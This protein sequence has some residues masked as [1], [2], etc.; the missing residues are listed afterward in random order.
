MVKRLLALGAFVV[1]SA[2]L[3]AQT[4]VITRPD[5]PPSATACAQGCTIQ[6]VPPSPPIPPPVDPPPPPPPP[7]PVDPPP[8][9]PPTDAR[10]IFRPD[11][12][13]AAFPRAG[14]DRAISEKFGTRWTRSYLPTGGPF[15]GPAHR[16]TELA[17]PSAQDC[18][19]QHGWGWDKG[20]GLAN[21]PPRGPN[22]KRY[23]RWAMRFT[24]A[25]NFRGANPST[26]CPSNI[27]SNK[28]LII[29]QGCDTRN[30]RV[31]LT[32]RVRENR[33]L[34]FGVAI[35]GGLHQTETGYII[36]ADGWLWVQLEVTPSTSTST[37]DGGWRLWVNG[38]QRLVRTGI[39]LDPTNHNYFGYGHYNNNALVAGGAHEFDTALFEVG[40]A[41]DATWGQAR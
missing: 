26:G 38:V 28:L 4:V 11:Y 27:S 13:A 30:C 40:T 25:S 7:P 17:T 3:S 18:G 23:Y 22:G 37:T 2:V 41:F 29:G 5:G 8:P 10:I 36:P 39:R 20:F 19:G 16:L 33:T 24:P 15:G 31:I 9:P 1:G 12:S 32:H 34:Q 21:D 14:W 35:D 6:I